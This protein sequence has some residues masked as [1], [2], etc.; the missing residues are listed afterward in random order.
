MSLLASGIFLATGGPA[1]V[2]IALARATLEGHPVLAAI[3]D[4]ST[5]ITLAVAIAGPLLVASV[6]I[7]IS[8]ALIARAASPTQ[9]HLLLAPLRA[10]ALLV[11]LGLS[12]ERMAIVVASAVEH[13]PLHL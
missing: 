7:E 1:R 4:L 10:L 3:G 11:V 8:G 12:F 5:G 6:V 2:A 9:L 13:A